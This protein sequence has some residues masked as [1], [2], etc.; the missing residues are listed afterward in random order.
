[1]TKKDKREEKI[2]ANPRNVS[3]EDFE[4][5]V[6]QYG[7]IKEGGSHPKAVINKRAFPYTRT[8]PIR[9]PYVRKVLEIIDSPGKESQPQEKSNGNKN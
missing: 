7:Y 4:A 3:L 2:R 8:N 9:P 6:N 5:L 1:M